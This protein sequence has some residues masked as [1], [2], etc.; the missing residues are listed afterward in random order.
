[1]LR[2][3]NGAP[4][5]SGVTKNVVSGITVTFKAGTNTGDTTPNIAP[6]KTGTELSFYSINGT[7]PN[8]GDK[9][10]AGTTWKSWDGTSDITASA[11]DKIQIIITD[12]NG[13]A[14]KGGEGTAIPK[15]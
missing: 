11:T 13:N 9:I 1:M 7:L 14:T 8:V 4:A 5:G 12:A 15:V 6:N 2:N 10:T 3:P